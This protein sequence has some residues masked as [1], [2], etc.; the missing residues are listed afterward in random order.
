M[1]TSAPDQR[2]YS[3]AAPSGTTAYDIDFLVSDALAVLDADGERVR[4]RRRC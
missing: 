4:Y 1:R 2:A 3:A